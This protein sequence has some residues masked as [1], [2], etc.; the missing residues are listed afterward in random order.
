MLH[1]PRNEYEH[2]RAGIE[3]KVAL[4]AIRKVVRGSDEKDDVKKVM[5][6]VEIVHSFEEDMK[7]RTGDDGSAT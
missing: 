4:Q 1:E 3:Y 2:M 7:R 5:E 6:I